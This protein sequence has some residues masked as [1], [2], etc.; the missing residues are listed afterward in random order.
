MEDVLERLWKDATDTGAA[1]PRIDVIVATHRHRDHVSGFAK[2]GWEHVLVREVWLPWTEHP[3]DAEAKRIRDT[4]SRL[5][6]T[7]E[8]SLT[9]RL[10]ALPLSAG[11][12]PHL[13]Q[14]LELARNSLS[15]DRAMAT[16]HDGFAGNPRR[17]FL[18]DVD[19]VEST[20]NTDAL[21]GITP[22]VIGPSRDKEVIRD[23]DPPVG[24]SYLRLMA[25]MAGG[26]T[27]P[28]PF[29]PEWAIDPKTWIDAGQG[30]DAP[31][32]LSKLLGTRT[33]TAVAL[34]FLSDD[35]QKAIAE[36]GDVQQA[37]AVSLDKAVNG[38]SLMIVLKVGQVHLLFP[39]DAQWG[40]WQ[41][42]FRNPAACE[43]LKRTTFYKVGHHGSHNS[44][45]QRLVEEM[46]ANRGVLSMVS[47][48]AV[49]Q[50]P[51][52]PRK[53]LLE[54]LTTHACIFARSDEPAKVDHD[55]FRATGD[56]FIDVS[57]PYGGAEEGL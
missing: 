57:I 54:A 38:T 2:P 32:L 20:I 50:W 9:A 16:L 37:V 29:A 34:P 35:D 13:E 52:I 18:P 31:A 41:A 15:N 39:G 8:A 6:A 17:R 42:A 19:Q 46:L 11:D 24:R 22:F 51:D 48:R 25:S 21:P 12:R 4:Q 43:L 55:I 23:M 27:A 33:N 30:P 53:Q 7:L 45:P 10:A 47:T 1:K 28:Q 26:T 44:T 3:T 14:W 40:S 5:A 49:A 36:I 56:L